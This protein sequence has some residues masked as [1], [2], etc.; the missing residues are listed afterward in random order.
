TSCSG[1]LPVKAIADFKDKD[2]GDTKPVT[3]E[4]KAKC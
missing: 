3:S 2:S 4:S 1:S